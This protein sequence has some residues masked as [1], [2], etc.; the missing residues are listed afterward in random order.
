MLMLDSNP[1]CKTMSAVALLATGK[2]EMLHSFP[3]IELASRPGQFAVFAGTACAA[4]LYFANGRLCCGLLEPCGAQAAENTPAETWAYYTCV[5]KS[6]G[7]KISENTA[8]RICVHNNDTAMVCE[9]DAA[10]KIRILF[11]VGGC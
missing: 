6:T 10:Q 3:T 8:N 7:W 4:K 5:C 1:I 11:S 2:Y 9:R